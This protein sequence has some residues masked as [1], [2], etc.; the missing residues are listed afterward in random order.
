MTTAAAQARDGQLLR[1]LHDEH[2]ASLWSFVSGL[3]NGD[4]VRAQ[5]VVQETLLRAWRNPEA[6]AAAATPRSW[7]FTV[8]KR[9]VIDDWRAA[10]RRP[11][12]VTDTLPERAATDT[13]EQTVNR[14]LVLAGL[15]A[16]SPE[17]REVLVECYFGGRSVSE[18]AD[19]LGVPEGTIKSRTHY[20]LHALRR[21]IGDLGGAA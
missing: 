21:A 17:H 7:L 11:E 1:A 9:I 14:E 15:R 19:R 4:R 6:I 12:I 13:A 20:A 3:L 2:A 10:R 16:L 8:A 18:A 5:D